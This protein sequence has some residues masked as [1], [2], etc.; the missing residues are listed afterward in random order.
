[1]RHGP[2]AGAVALSEFVGSTIRVKF[3]ANIPESFTGPASMQIDNVSLTA[4]GHTEAPVITLTGDNPQTVEVFSSY[5]ELG[6][7]M[8]DN[9]D[10]DV[11]LDGNFTAVMLDVLGEYPVTYDATDSSGNAADQVIR[12][13][14]VVDT[15][16]PVI[17]LVGGTV[18]VGLVRPTPTPVPRQ[19]TTTTPA[20]K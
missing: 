19:S 15:E 9:V 14:E 11:A 2:G 16:A 4:I 13:V 1:M 12:T 5:I 17:S 20:S 10:A 6:A 3:L 7:T 18:T 8:S